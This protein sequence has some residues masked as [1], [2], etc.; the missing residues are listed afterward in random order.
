MRLSKIYKVK[1]YKEAEKKCPKGYRPPYLWELIK[2]IQ[3][4]PKLL[5]PKEGWVLYFTKQT[6]ADKKRNIFRGAYLLENGYWYSD[7]NYLGY[8]SGNG[9]VVY[10]EEA[11]A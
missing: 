10:V 2:L 1:T 3:E 4:Q 8:S 7:S 6:E 9:R 5:I 11:G